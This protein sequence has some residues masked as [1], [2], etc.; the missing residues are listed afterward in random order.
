[1]IFFTSDSHFGHANI[2][3]FCKRPYKWVDE[4][5]EDLIER[6]NRVVTDS[7]I[8]YYLGDFSFKSD[9]SEYLCRLNGREHHL[10]IGNHD[11]RKQCERIFTSVQDVKLL[12]IKE[13]PQIWLSH[14]AHQAWPASHFGSLHLFGHSH[15]TLPVFPK[16]KRMDVGVD[17]LG[18][19]PISLERVI[20]LLT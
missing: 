10:I 13:Y 15:G 11:K 5:N 7:D 17:S 8:V 19:Y 6:H 2:I 14:Y 3:K 1:M 18:Y 4:M 16:E 12:N 9:P 20:K